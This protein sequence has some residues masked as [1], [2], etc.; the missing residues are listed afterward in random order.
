MTDQPLDRAVAAGQLRHALDAALGLPPADV[1]QIRVLIDAG[2]LRVALET[3]CTQA[4]EYDI[5]LS[6]AQREALQAL[7][8]TLGVSVRYLLGDPWADTPSGNASQ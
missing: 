2:E 8:D 3:L 5:E 7:G 4:Y 6:P 1:D